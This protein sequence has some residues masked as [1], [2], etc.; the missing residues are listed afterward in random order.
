MILHE[1]LHIDCA[2][3]I[4]GSCNWSQFTVQYMCS[5]FHVHALSDNWRLTGLVGLFHAQLH[6]DAHGGLTTDNTK[7]PP[8][9]AKDIDFFRHHESETKLSNHTTSQPVSI[10]NGAANGSRLTPKGDCGVLAYYLFPLDIKSAHFYSFCKLLICT[11][12]EIQ[13]L[14]VPF[15]VSI[16]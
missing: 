6:I 16:H 8:A 2:V 1:H 3:P 5:K 10:A 14:H 13:G 12:M 4:H 9:D 11:T 7:S 15:Q